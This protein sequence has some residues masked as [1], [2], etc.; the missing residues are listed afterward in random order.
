VAGWT[1]SPKT[2]DPIGGYPYLM[3]KAYKIP[4]LES[5]AFAGARFLPSTGQ[6]ASSP[7][8]VLCLPHFR[9]QRGS[10][11]R[12]KPRGI[13]GGA[14]SLSPRSRTRSQLGFTPCGSPQ[15]SR[16]ERRLQAPRYA[17]TYKTGFK[18]PGI[19]RRC[20]LQLPPPRSPSFLASPKGKLRYI[21]D[22]SG[23]QSTPQWK[24][25]RT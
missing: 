8:Q 25:L 23:P 5:Y 24:G 20:E 22:P 19:F 13:S 7:T 9:K 10:R 18:S 1:P 14:V 17:R 12:W 4:W 21:A 3:N 16:G 11:F 2:T 15:L 6:S